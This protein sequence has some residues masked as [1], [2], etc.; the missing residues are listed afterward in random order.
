M[1]GGAHNHDVVVARTTPLLRTAK[2]SSVQSVAIEAAS[3][4]IS[5]PRRARYN[6]H[7]VYVLAIADV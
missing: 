7:T 6:G 3:S 2:M 1:E 4:A 5:S